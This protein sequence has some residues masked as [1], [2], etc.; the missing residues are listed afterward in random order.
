MQTCHL[1][2]A[3]VAA[4]VALAVAGCRRPASDE[5]DR[6]T[7]EALP[8]WSLE[9]VAAI[10]GEFGRI[11]GLAVDSHG[12]IYVADGMRQRIDIFFAGGESLG[13]LGRRGSGPGEFTGLRDIAIGH[14][15]T[16]YALDVQSQ[17]VTAFAIDG[18][19][20][21]AETVPVA[22]AGSRANY[23]IFAP[24]AGGL[25]VLYAVPATDETAEAARPMTLRHLSGSA[26]R[27][28]RDVLQLP[29]KEFLVSRDPSFGF[30]VGEMPYGR[31]PFVRLGPDDMVHFV[32]SD[33][34][35]VQRYA[36]DGAES[37]G[38][39]VSLAPGRVDDADVQALIDSF[40]TDAF[41]QISRALMQRAHAEGRLPRTRPALKN[42]LLDEQGRIWANLV[43][44]DDVVLNTPAGMV[45]RGRRPDT[46]SRWLVFDAV[47]NPTA[48]I[49]LSTGMALSIVRGDEAW[50]VATDDLGVERVLRYSIRR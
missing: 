32:W 16:L 6:A 2:F 25:L 47:G 28:S 10:D 33:A 14:A 17:R 23:R 42:L 19:P 45:Y 38:F 40:E 39:R 18:E 26:L 48:K 22:R 4:L 27:D 46:A 37:E 49:D 21:L 11:V 9:P 1:R 7:L 12:R 29:E 15:D 20:R 50:G 44:P 36:I 13:T 31:E 43:T 24:S 34:L 30:A 41:S 3:A 35:E 5:P 8:R